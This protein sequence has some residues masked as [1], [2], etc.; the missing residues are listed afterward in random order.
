METATRSGSLC[1]FRLGAYHY[2][3]PLDAIG[4]VVESGDI[5]PLPGAPDFV[6]GL[7]NVRGE[8]I[9]VIDITPF[10]GGERVVPAFE[11]PLLILRDEEGRV[12]VVAHRVIGVREM[13]TDAWPSD[14]T[15]YILHEG[16]DGD[17]AVR[18][19]D[20]A[21]ILRDGRRELASL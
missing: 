4:E 11:N 3:L 5:T 18:L 15:H 1:L 12:G 17:G 16:L 2:A 7:A 21:R 14:E 20:V 13:P 6:M 9:P 10:V 8:I 19:I